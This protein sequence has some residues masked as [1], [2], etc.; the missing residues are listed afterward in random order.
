MHDI[1]DLKALFTSQRLAVLATQ[2]EG[3]PHESLVAFAC[4][5]DLKYILLATSRDTRKYHDMQANPRVAVLIDNRSSE[6]SDFQ[7]AIAV[8]A[9]GIVENPGESDVERYEKIYLE[10]HPHL[11][12]FILDPNVAL[13]TID[14][15]EYLIAGF[16]S[17]QSIKP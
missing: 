1:S 15:N 8:T 3:Q 16:R 2:S 5:D 11:R 7:Q 12:E 13:V 17:A 10:K 9:K 14:V 6:E 4:S